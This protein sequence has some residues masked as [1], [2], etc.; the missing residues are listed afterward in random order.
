M[1]QALTVT[2]LNQKGGVGKST[3]AV[4]LAVEFSKL[5]KTLLIDCDPMGS[6]N[7]FGNARSQRMTED[8]QL[9]VCSK[10]FRN[11][12][13]RE[14]NG[15][16][17]RQEIKS[18]KED[19]EMIFIDSPGRSGILGKALASVSD[20]VIVPMAPGI[21]DSWGADETKHALNEVMA[22]N[23]DIKARVLMNRRDDR[24]NLSKVLGRFIDEGDIPPMKTALGSRTIYGHSG[25]GLSVVELDA[26]S[27]AAGEIREL[28]SEIQTILGINS[29]G[30]E[31]NGNERSINRDAATSVAS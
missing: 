9:T 7:D 12:E 21:F 15:K 3:I 28:V 6:C 13:G 11:D 19:Y 5:Y 18:F 23:D 26:R 25:A 4:N 10:I 27:E 22:I 20:L 24:T 8:N 30:G 1:A 31:T 2:L 29:I 17:I 14:V 16:L